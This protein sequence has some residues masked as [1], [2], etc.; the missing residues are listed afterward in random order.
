MARFS[1]RSSSDELSRRSRP[2]RRA[3]KQCPSNVAGSKPSP[4]VE[5]MLR[6][7]VPRSSLSFVYVGNLRSDVRNEDLEQLFAKKK[8]GKVVEVDIR[9]CSG[10][11]VP[12]GA[13]GNTVYATVL[14]ASVEGA[15]KALA[16]NGKRLLGKKLVVSPSFLGLPEAKR[17]IRRRAVQVFGVNLT[18]LSDKVH[19]TI[20][21]VRLG[22][23]QVFPAGR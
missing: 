5:P 9:C 11:A 18:K 16:M 10:T 1:A 4:K 13:R 20:D 14:F 6:Q 17:G 7:A 2:S 22:G 23:T 3:N 19:R 15:T 12:S 21:K 8:I